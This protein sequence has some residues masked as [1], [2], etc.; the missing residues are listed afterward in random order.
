VDGLRLDA[1]PYLIEREGTD[2]ENLPETHEVLKKMRAE[3]DARYENRLFLAEA[4]QWPED[5]LPYFGDGD[6]CHM[7][8]HFPLMPRIFMA[9]AQEDRH[10]IVEIMHQTPEIPEGCQWAIFLRNHDELTLEMVTDRERDYM[11]QIY[12]T[13][14]RMRINVGIRRRLASMMENDRPRIELLNSLLM[15]MPGTPIIYY[16]D[17]IGMGDNIFLGDRDAVRTPMQWSSDRNA[18]FSR[19]EPARLYLPPVM[20]PVYSYEAVNVESQGRSAGS[21]LNWMK[22][23]IAVRKAHRAFGRGTLEFLHP[24]N[25]KVLAYLREHEGEAILCVANLSRSAQPVEL[26][27]SR[28]R[29][30]V[31]VELLGNSSFPPLGDLPYFLTLPGYGF[32]WFRL[33]REAAAPRWHQESP[34]YAEPPVLVLPAGRQTARSVDRVPLR[35]PARQIS[36][37]E[38]EALPNFLG[39]RRWFAA[40]AGGIESVQVVAQAAFADNMLLTM[41]EVHVGEEASEGAEPQLYFLPLSAAWEEGAEGDGLSVYMP[42]VLTKLRRRARVGVLLDALSDEAFCRRVV[43]AMGENTEMGVGEGEVHFSGTDVF[44]E[45]VGDE[46]ADELSV[47]RA[48]VEQTNSSVILGERL[49]LKAYR[50][51]QKGTNPDLEIGR[52]LTEKARFENT[53][54]LAGA[55]EYTGPDGET[56]TLGLLQGFVENQGDGW[57][58]VL[59]YLD[60]YLEDRLMTTWSPEGEDDEAE[61]LAAE[62]A[63]FTSLVRVLGLRTGELHAAFAAPTDDE[64][65]APETAFPEEV[66]GWAD[67][68]LAEARH[69][70]DMLKRRRDSLPDEAVPDADRLLALRKELTGSIERVAREDF[71]VVKTRH[72]GDYHLGQ[73]LVVGNDFQI[74]DFEGEPA[75]PLAERRKKHSPLRDVAGMLRSFDY[76][77]RSALMDL[78]AERADQ[79]EGLEPWVRLWKER[80]SQAFLDGYR[81]G[82]GDDVSYPEEHAPALIE[83]FTLEKALYEIRYELDNRPDWVGIPIMSVVDLLEDRP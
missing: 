46:T 57:S 17:E 65:F 14:P 3:M 59:D 66:A 1:I 12:A 22:R 13:D 63:F 32:Y 18:G 75:R 78:G 28:F 7:A 35:L 69:T 20:D 82:V 58:Y 72:H 2:N 43:A 64:A 53:P 36:Q 76:A 51:L 8:F 67:G 25:R 15:S 21:L 48:E 80:T 40:K 33:A 61:E 27:L 50:R 68:V 34:P 5:V 74:I 73:V 23:L 31:P 47:R 37:L 11:Y 42:D 39:T 56:T 41:L 24:G 26:D 16:G 52:Y 81:E 44:R 55:I 9:L 77:I 38:R 71:E 79:L 19:A 10:P 49:I 70:L 83:L 4:N 6:E 54:P 29:G 45:L 30:M 60:R 62:D